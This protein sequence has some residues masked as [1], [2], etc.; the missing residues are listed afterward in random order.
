MT[1]DRLP[2]LGLQYGPDTC[3]L[4]A[5]SYPWYDREPPTNHNPNGRRS[6][7]Q[8]GHVHKYPHD[9]W[10]R[11]PARVGRRRTVI[12]L[13]LEALCDYLLKKP[14]LHLDE[15]SSSSGMSPR[16]F[17]QRPVFSSFCSFVQSKYSNTLQPKAYRLTRSNNQARILKKCCKVRHVWAVYH[18]LRA[19]NLFRQPLANF[20]AWDP[21]SL[22]KDFVFL[23]N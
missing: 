7:M 12:S 6:W 4:K 18:P 10:K 11:G 3:P 22:F 14:S 5:A 15:S 17:L 1:L 2:T 19:D 13:I 16:P 21:R 20:S 23:S 9:I 8:Q